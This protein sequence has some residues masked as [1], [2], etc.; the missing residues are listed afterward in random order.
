L[1]HD[2]KAAEI[3]SDIDFKI[4]EDQDINDFQQLKLRL[5]K[6]NVKMKLDAGLGNIYLRKR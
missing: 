3:C 2:V 1:T 5:K 4:N 6:G